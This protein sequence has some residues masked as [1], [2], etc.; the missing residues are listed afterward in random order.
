MA[1]AIEY[2]RQKRAFFIIDTP[3]GV[4]EL[5]EIT[6]WM[7]ERDTLRADNAAIYYPR[8]QTPDPLDNFRLR[9]FRASGTIAGL[10]ARTD[11]NRGVWTGDRRYGKPTC[12]TY[13][14]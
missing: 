5:P 14:N 6:N 9:S 7:E 13:P 3:L 2:C 10:Y 1:A 8:V 12:A 4:D 11:S